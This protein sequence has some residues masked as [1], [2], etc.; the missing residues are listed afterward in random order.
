MSNTPSTQ[1]ARK[2]PAPDIFGPLIGTVLFGYYGFLAGLDT[3][4]SDGNPVALW[5]TFVWTLRG[6]TVL[7][8]LSTV[9]AIR[10]APRSMLAYGI[11]VAL[12]TASLAAVFLWDTMS[13]DSLAVHPVILLVLVV[14]NGYCALTAIRDGLAELR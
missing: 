14:W 7:L 1:P 13:P 3:H 10:N 12:A 4:G 2:A 9:L 5:I 11:S 8:A 6:A